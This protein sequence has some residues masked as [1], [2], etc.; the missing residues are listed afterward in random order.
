MHKTAEENLEVI[1]KMAARY[2]DNVIANVL[3]K[4]G[5]RTGKGKPWSQV[6]VKTA[7]RNHGIEG[8]A[9][10]IEDPGVLT[11]QEAIAYTDTSDTT[12]RKLVD[13]GV[14]PMRQVAPFAPWE[15]QR[16][17]LDSERVRVVLARLKQT[18]RVMLGHASET[19]R[20]LFE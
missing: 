7:R 17:D 13:A 3:N 12:I 9:R 18:G 6:A 8:H 16:S 10:T 14:L 2:G 11:L 5:R 4:L 1:R 20:D 19:Q 15:I